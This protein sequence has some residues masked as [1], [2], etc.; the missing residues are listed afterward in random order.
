[1]KEM[2]YGFSVSNTK[3]GREIVKYDG[4]E[5]KKTRIGAKYVINYEKLM[6]YLVKM[7]YVEANFDDFDEN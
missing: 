5:K 3:F 4:I 7:S 6:K 1:L 2:E